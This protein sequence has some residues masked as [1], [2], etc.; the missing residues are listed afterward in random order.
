MST[1]CNITTLPVFVTYRTGA[2]YVHCLWLYKQQHDNPVRSKLSVACQRWWF[3]W[4]FWFLPSVLGYLRE[5]KEHN[6]EPWHKPIE[7][8]HMGMHLEKEVAR[9]IA[10][11]H[12]WSHAQSIAAVNAGLKTLWPVGGN[13]A[14]DVMKGNFED[15]L[16]HR[17]NCIQLS[18]VYCVWQVVKNLT[19][20]SNNP[21][22]VDSFYWTQERYEIFFSF[23]WHSHIF[24]HPVLFL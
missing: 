15:F 8:N 24:W 2:V 21:V 11:D 17:C 12:H 5:E 6:P 7:R 18:Q 3:Q 10:S 22:Y 20:F 13:R 23:L 9:R 19:I 4:R 1:Y 16:I 14:G